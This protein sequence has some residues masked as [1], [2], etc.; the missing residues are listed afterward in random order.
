MKLNAYKVKGLMMLLLVG[1]NFSNFGCY[2]FKKWIEDTPE[3]RT[4]TSK[5]DKDYKRTGREVTD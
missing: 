5:Y 3:D 2:S 4:Y 1:L